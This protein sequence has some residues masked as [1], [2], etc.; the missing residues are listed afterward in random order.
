MDP[1]LKKLLE[2]AA[3]FPDGFTVAI[4]DGSLVE[5]NWLYGRKE[6]RGPKGLTVLGHVFGVVVIIGDAEAVFILHETTGDLNG[7]SE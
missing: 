4:P 3:K 6:R 2:I 7:S 5:I 1:L